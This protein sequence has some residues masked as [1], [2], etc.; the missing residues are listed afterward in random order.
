[1]RFHRL[2]P[3]LTLPAFVAFAAV[4]VRAD[5]VVVVEEHPAAAAVRATIPDETFDQWVFGGQAPAAARARLDALLELQVA[6][7]E[8]VGDVSEAKRTRLQLAGRN[9]I[10]RF[11]D[12]VDEA[13]KRFQVLKNEPNRL[14]E[15]YHEA[16]RL[17]VEI[18]AGL[19]G[20]R[21]F[22]TKTL[23]TILTAKQVERYE[24]SE[25]ERLAFRRQAHLEAVVAAL[26]GEIGLRDDQRREVT[27]VLGEELG[28][29]EFV[30]PYA[31]YAAL[32]RIS[33]LREDKL[34]PVFDA[35]QWRVLSRYFDRAKA[36]EPFLRQQ[37][38]LDDAAAH[39]KVDAAQRDREV[40]R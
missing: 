15:T 7:V 29:V 13:R 8:R 12:R 4:S 16:Q 35:S 17:Q 39:P 18:Q 38:L 27:R 31:Y 9:D 34:K 30:G 1:M 25:R 23:Q 22:F 21:S 14:N 19:F 11:L 32:I 33:R 37:G 24:Q 26:D 28:V 2:S 6:A 36:L 3:L 5:D 40:V 10:R 20:G